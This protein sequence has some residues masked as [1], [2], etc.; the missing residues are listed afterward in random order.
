MLPYP[1]TH[2]Q[3]H[4]SHAT[5]PNLTCETMSSPSKAV[6]WECD[7]CAYTNKDATRHYCLVCQ[8]KHPIRYAIVAGITT[9]AMARTTRVN[10]CKQ[11]PIAALATAEPAIAGEVA[12]SPMQPL[13][14]RC[15][16]PP[17]GHLL[18]QR[19]WPCPLG[20]LPNWGAIVQALSLTWS[21]R[22]ST[23]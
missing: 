19:V 10:H 13:L 15:L 16:L 17:T 8:T 9:A 1:K 21:T 12:T 3:T 14:G 18:W 22:W 6:A 5:L 20:R 7:M 4:N 11:A 23:L 2:P